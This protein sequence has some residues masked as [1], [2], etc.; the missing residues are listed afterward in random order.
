MRI[1]EKLRIGERL[2]N[3]LLF[4]FLLI[5]LI[6]FAA[7][8]YVGYTTLVSGAE[9]AVVREM[10]AIADSAAQTINVY[11]ND[12]V[13]DT[14]VW[15]DSRLIKEAVEVAELREDASLYLREAVKLYG[16]YEAILLVDTRGSCV[17]SSWPKAI[18]GNFSNEEAF[19]GAMTG[20]LS[21]H[22]FHL[23]PLVKEINEK[24]RGGTVV[25]GAPV[26]VG[27]KTVG[28]VLSY[29]KWA[30]IE[31]LVLGIK[32]ADTG[33]VWVVNS[34]VQ[35]I[36]HPRG[37]KDGWYLEPV[38]GPKINLPHLSAAI[39]SKQTW[40]RYSFLNA[41]TNKMDEKTS[42]WHY[43]TDYGHFKSLGWVIG[44]GADRSEVMA[45]LPAIIRL[46]G[47]IGAVIVAFVVVGV[48]LI[49][50]TISRPIT[51]LAEVMT[52]VGTELDLTL[53]APVTTRDETGRAAEALNALLDRLQ[54]AFSA[55][56]DAV[57][58]VRQASANV[59]Q[60]TQTIV[61]NATAQAERARNVLER[62]TVM[63]ETAREVS[64]N[65][66]VSL[67]EASSTGATLQNIVVQSQD[68]TKKAENQD[69][70]TVEAEAIIEAMGAT[71]REVSGK[72]SEQYNAARE[73]AEAVNRMARTIEEMARSA[74]EA[75]RQSETTDRFAREGGNAV[76]KVVQGMK[77][78]AESSEQINEIMVVIS[79]IA[80]QTNL[81]A[82][83]AAIEAA[84][85][86]E[87][88]K[89]F[90]VVADE[91]RK[92]AERTAESTNE[93]ADLIKES[94]KRVEEGERLSAMSREALAQIQDAVAKTNALIAGISEGTLRQTEDAAKVQAA[95]ERLTT[96]AQEIM[97]LTAEQAKRRQRAA[98]IMADLRGLS[99]EILDGSASQA[100]TA[101]VA[102][103]EM[104]DVMARS[105]NITKLTGL[106]TERAAAL[107]QIMAEMAE[108]AS[109][110]AQA[111]AG[112]GGTT[113]ELVRIADQLGVL[114]EQFRLTREM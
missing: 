42:A 37:P 2:R 45:Y 31:Q 1:L 55:V 17:A 104:A 102:N 51:R 15:A 74:L 10:K 72:A 113:Q 39:R 90:A 83:N 76:D 48:L 87:H 18:G 100:Q 54:A 24:S 96:L 97:G 111:A 93:I 65:A 8:S 106:Q 110:N 14:M 53:R 69:N 112:V 30:P 22:D 32:V 19:T 11:M 46:Q 109:T 50:P 71:A 13:S 84:R 44:A 73:T 80:E 23:S 103:Q 81:L 36:V 21:L 7:A 20:K 59:N 34:K 61:V 26:T 57:G 27:G 12:R 101:G 94:N 58:T 33:Y 64:G 99:R 41:K 66:E 107:R 9:E 114:V 49:A 95:M 86:G 89:G 68:I 52:Q 47:T 88:G 16:T 35:L 78:I 38:D 105:D 82:L 4:Y 60:A 98:E 6:P 75:A 92:L 56:M 25:I 67:K 28:A 77:G 91:V 79:S 29:V 62:V 3:K 43:Q 40:M 5:S 108:V 85:A 70:R 63:G